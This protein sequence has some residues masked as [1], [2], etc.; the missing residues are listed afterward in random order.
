MS[1]KYSF[2]IFLAVLLVLSVYS[3][4]VYVSFSNV[5]DTWML[6]TNELTTDFELS[7]NYFHQVFAQVNDIQYSPLNTLYYALIYQIDGFNPFYYHLFSI[8]LHLLNSFL[9]FSIVRKILS[10]ESHL[11]IAVIALIWAVHPLNVETVIWISASKILLFS[12]FSLL[13]LRIFLKNEKRGF[14]SILKIFALLTLACLCKEQ[15]V[16]TALVI[17]FLDI[18]YRKKHSLKLPQCLEYILYLAVFVF[19]AGLSVAIN[20]DS[21]AKVGYSVAERISLAFYS[22]FWYTANT[23]F[24][25]DL[26]YN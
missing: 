26:H 7:F 14:S 6:L 23:F 24:P 10:T 20:S 4:F 25:Y 11:R 9:V 12:F 13:A 8:V 1:K 18:A 19:F 17:L 5:D 15:A 2:H 22:V 3:G 16:L 21:I